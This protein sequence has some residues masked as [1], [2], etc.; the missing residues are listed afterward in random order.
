MVERTLMVLRMRSG[1]PDAI[2]EAFAAHDSTQLPFLLGARSRTLFRFQDLYLHLVESDG[3]LVDR[4]Y[5]S[6]QD[7]RFQEIN[8]AIGRLVQ[9]YSPSFR[10]LRDNV[11]KEFYHHSFNR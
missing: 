1:N 6:H 8:T 2:A 7:P 5:S 3:D 10:E 4:L 11:A 9:P